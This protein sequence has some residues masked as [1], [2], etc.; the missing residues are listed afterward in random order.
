MNRP[1]P[2]GI[3]TVREAYIAGLNPTNATSRLI[4]N[5]VSGNAPHWSA[6]SGRVYSIWWTTNLLEN[7]QPLERGRLESLPHMW[8][9]LSSLL[10][11]EERFSE[12]GRKLGF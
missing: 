5:S 4:L 9:R 1:V 11:R 12:I 10:C 6:I 8:S 2:N 7:F 3:N